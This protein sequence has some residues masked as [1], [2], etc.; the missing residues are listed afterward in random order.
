MRRLALALALVGACGEAPLPGALDGGPDASSD[1]RAMGDTPS[2]SE[3]PAGDGASE[4]RPGMVWWDPSRVNLVPGGWDPAPLGTPCSEAR[5]CAAGAACV[6]VPGRG[7]WCA[8]CGRPGTFCCDGRCDDS[9]TACVPRATP[10]FFATGSFCFSQDREALRGRAGGVCLEMTRPLCTDRSV[11]DGASP[12][13]AA[14]VPLGRLG[15]PCDGAWCWEGRPLRADR[16][17]CLCVR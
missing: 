7:A 14:C 17:H 15:M 9:R 2:R 12:L 3:A 13:R 10:L 1:A 8:L 11:C 5:A 4:P 6:T 16:A